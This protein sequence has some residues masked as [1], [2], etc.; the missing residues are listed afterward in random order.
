MVEE[1]GPVGGPSPSLGAAPSLSAAP[2]PAA[3]PDGLG[4]DELNAAPALAALAEVEKLARVDAPPA[5]APAA[6]DPSAPLTL[7]P[8]P[9]APA[10]AG[11]P[12][13]E[14]PR[15]VDPVLAGFDYAVALAGYVLL[16]ISVFMAGVPA[17]ATF[18][19]AY[20]HRRDAHLLA[21]SHF[22]FQLRIFYT[23]LLFIALGAGSLVAAGG[24]ALS[25]LIRFAHDHL[26]GLAGAMTQAHVDAWSGTIA[27]ALLAAAIV[28]FILTVIWL[29]VASL[30]G[31]LRLLAGRSIGHRHAG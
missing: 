24:L 27:A 22:Q 6:P 28:F 1:P 16:F 2:S 13:G 5:A 26:P 12:P 15:I 30:F 8:K 9:S 19:L 14:G 25:R 17:L 7:T 23:A 3:A 29:L 4:L 21:R 31:F 11:P 20:A 10:H 18:A